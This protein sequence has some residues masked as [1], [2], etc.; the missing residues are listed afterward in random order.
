MGRTHTVVSG[1]L[2]GIGLWTFIV[3]YI[4]FIGYKSFVF[5]LPIILVSIGMLICNFTNMFSILCD[6]DIFGGSSGFNE[7]ERMNK[8]VI[9]VGLVIAFSGIIFSLFLPVQLD[10]YK[11]V[12]ESWVQL[13]GCFFCFM[14]MIVYQYSNKKDDSIF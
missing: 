9:F 5:M 4:N 1:G 10:D 7:N 3:S 14:A 2:Y 11:N 8:F 6:N 12:N 13:L